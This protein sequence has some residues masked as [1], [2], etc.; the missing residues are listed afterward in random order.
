[1]LHCNAANGAGGSGSCFELL[2]GLAPLRFGSGRTCRGNVGAPA[3]GWK[4]L[5]DLDDAVALREHLVV[6]TIGGLK[7]DPAAKRVAGADV[8]LPR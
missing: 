3:F 1:M 4:H 6:G 8:E 2:V 7:I 5:D